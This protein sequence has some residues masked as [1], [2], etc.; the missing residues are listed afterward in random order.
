M[1]KERREEEMSKKRRK[2]EREGREAQERAEEE[3]RGISSGKSKSNGT[4]NVKGGEAKGEEEKE[5]EDGE[6]RIAKEG[7]MRRGEG[8]GGQGEKRRKGGW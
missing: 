8:K 5:E 3:M 6:E 4:G 7:E 2:W 1:V